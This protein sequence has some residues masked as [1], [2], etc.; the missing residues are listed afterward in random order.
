[1]SDPS[2]S[3]GRSGPERHTLNRRR[4][5]AWRPPSARRSRSGAR[6]GRGGAAPARAN[7]RGGTAAYASHGGCHHGDHR[8]LGAVPRPSWP[9]DRSLVIT[10]RMRAGG[11]SPALLWVWENRE[12]RGVH[13]EHQQSQ[14]SPFGGINHVGINP[15]L[16]AATAPP[17]QCVQY[18]ITY[19]SVRPMPGGRINR[20]STLLKTL[21]GYFVRP[22]PPRIA[23]RSTVSV[24]TPDSSHWASVHRH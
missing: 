20:P 22:R 17:L 7:D 10:I 24:F 8:W 1:M 2:R 4:A 12:K 9:W 19:S 23:D 16:A 13:T 5:G 21:V 11:S 18:S 3:G 14:T 6:T 15:K